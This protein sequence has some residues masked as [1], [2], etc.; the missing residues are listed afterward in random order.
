MNIYTFVLAFLMIFAVITNTLIFKKNTSK[1]ISKSYVGFMKSNRKLLNKYEMNFYKNIKIDPATVDHKNK[2]NTDENKTRTINIENAKL[3]I[4]PLFSEDADSA[5]ELFKITANLIKTL[6]QNKSFYKK[7]L[8][9]EL[10]NQMIT[11]Y[12]NLE[13]KPKNIFLEKIKLKDQNYQ[14]TYYKILKGTKFYNFEKNIGHGSLLDFVTVD[15]SKNSKI[16]IIDAS[17]ELL[18]SL[19]GSSIAKKIAL[20]QTQNPPEKLAFEN[21]SNIVDK[22]KKF[23]NYFDFSLKNL[24][25]DSQSIFA[26]DEDTQIKR[27]K[28]I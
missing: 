7:G 28:T 8:E 15:N 20:L 9:V 17:N 23:L 12:K 1:Y 5:K 26:I 11:S 13:K 2:K 27:K 19:F 3:N 4:F 18:T 22:N 25:S 6:Y 24:K 16:P 10:L 14:M 21:I